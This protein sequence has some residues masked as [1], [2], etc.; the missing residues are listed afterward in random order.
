MRTH[1]ATISRLRLA[2]AILMV[3][4]T[5]QAAHGDHARL[6]DGVTPLMATWL[7]GH[8]IIP[9]AI[10]KDGAPY[11]YVYPHTDPS[12]IIDPPWTEVAAR[13]IKVGT[14][15]PAVLFL[16]GCHG[17]I[18]GGLGYR[19][20]L[21]SV[22]YAIF[23]PDAFARPGHSCSTSTLGRRRQELA[24]ALSQI[25][26]LPWVDHDRIILMGESE[27]GITV[28]EWEK[29]GFAAHAILASNCDWHN[30]TQSSPHAPEGVPVLA[31]VGAKDEFFEGSS[32]HVSRR[33]GGSQSITIP[34]AGHDI[35]EHPELK[36]ALRDFLRECCEE[37]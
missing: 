16:H 36:R 17:L 23:E 3:S 2:I 25:R 13:H 20:L 6:P 37:G 19:K 18:R 9:E 10:T 21:M 31:V 12:R 14:K 27:G 28:A 33:V 4:L 7:W 29:P 22:G 32:C 1:G 11:V 5:G 34:G 8:Y 15:A 30:N 35:L 24:Y 26:K